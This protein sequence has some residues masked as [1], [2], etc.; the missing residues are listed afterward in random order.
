MAR[1]KFEKWSERF[2][3]LGQKVE[4]ESEKMIDLTDERDSK[5]V[6]QPSTLN[7]DDLNVFPILL[8][9]LKEQD[10]VIEV[11]KFKYLTSCSLLYTFNMSKTL[12][13]LG[14]HNYCVPIDFE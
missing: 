11:R 6:Q 10:I 4:G 13:C 8:E 7:D 12:H 14:H 9:K 5:K 1:L 2:R 3:S